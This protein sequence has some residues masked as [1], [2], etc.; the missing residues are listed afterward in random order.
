MLG[1]SAW[2]SVTWVSLHVCRSF[3]FVSEY[4]QTLLYTNGEIADTKLEPPPFD[5][6]IL[7]FQEHSRWLWLARVFSLFLQGYSSNL[8]PA[9]SGT[10]SCERLEDI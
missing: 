2:A 10:D 7:S 3:S 4:E 5:S 6:V 1:M 9:T 8:R